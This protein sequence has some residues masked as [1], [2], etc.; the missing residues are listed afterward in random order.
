MLPA[1]SAAMLRRLGNLSALHTLKLQLHADNAVVAH[2][3]ERAF[4]ESLLLLPHLQR[5]S[6]WW[7]L[8]AD[9][10]TGRGSHTWHL[11]SLTELTVSNDLA[12]TKVGTALVAP[13]LLRF[14]G[15]LSGATVSSLQK[16]SPLLRSLVTSN[17][18]GGWLCEVLR[19]APW[20]LLTEMD[21]RGV[22]TVLP[23][24]VLA[25]LARGGSPALQD[26]TLIVQNEADPRA[27]RTLLRS[28]PKLRS[29]RI[30]REH[31]GRRL[32]PL[33]DS[34]E[35]DSAAAASEAA[36]LDSGL[37]E[38]DGS[39]SEGS[40]G[41][42][43]AADDS[44]EEGW[45]REFGEVKDGK[46]A[47]E[48]GKQAKAL[49]CSAALPRHKLVDLENEAFLQLLQLRQERPLELLSKQTDSLPC[50]RTLMLQVTTGDTLRDLHF[51]QLQEL[52]ING[53]CQDAH[54]VLM[55]CPVTPQ[56]LRGVVELNSR[57]VV[58]GAE[59]VHV[60]RPSR[61]VCQSG[62][63]SGSRN[64]A[65]APDELHSRRWRVWPHS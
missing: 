49:S 58:P 55:E 27:V 40:I 4:S 52:Q 50:L 23:G 25:D 1:V 30:Y 57:F 28:L 3:I 24:Q 64:A 54:L 45:I 41:E 20:P 60:G 13:S 21:V 44:D 31:R 11:P 35:E 48:E 63:R 8:S 17:A 59:A 5:L 36:D 9:A 37:L 10:S 29:L 38:D 46:Q 47:K 26:L 51:P 16:T 33:W 18:H 39:G 65:A 56:R 2:D 34:D 32:E 43:S 6:V 15:V 19:K 42:H 62:R 7:Q 12:W 22:A 61:H 14:S 53:L